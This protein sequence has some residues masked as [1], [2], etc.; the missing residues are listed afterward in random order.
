MGFQLLEL[1]LESETLFYLFIQFEFA[2]WGYSMQGTLR[3]ESSIK[4]CFHQGLWQEGI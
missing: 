4:Q 1:V 3:L 2:K